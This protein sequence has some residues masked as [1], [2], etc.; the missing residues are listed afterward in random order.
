MT[1]TQTIEEIKTIMAYLTESCGGYPICLDEAIRMMTEDGQKLEEI[2][3]ITR[4][5]FSD[6]ETQD[7]NLHR[8][9]ALA[10]ILTIFDHGLQ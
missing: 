10:N 1:R 9:Q 4:E 8:A 3:N 5:A 7:I 6:P 2:E